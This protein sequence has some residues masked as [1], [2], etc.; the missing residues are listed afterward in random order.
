MV[1]S[2]IAGAPIAL[3]T[4]VRNQVLRRLLLMIIWQ[5]V[6][7][8][9]LYAVPVKKIWQQ[10]GSLLPCLLVLICVR[11]RLRLLVLICV[12]QRLRLLLHHA[13]WPCCSSDNSQAL[14]FPS[15]RGVFLARSGS[16]RDHDSK[17]APTVD[18][19]TRQID[20][21]SNLLHRLQLVHPAPPPAT[22]P[23]STVVALLRNNISK[24][25]IP[26]DGTILYNPTCWG[27]F[28]A[29]SSYHAALANDQ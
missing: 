29:P 19:C 15:C 17:L 10:C 16:H 14:D 6:M 12:R 3:L 21:G 8:P 2:S 20:A 27:F 22:L 23:T 25:R 5:Q 9:A 24:P 26:S 13:A 4:I 1:V 11:Q 28:V 7:C 18:H